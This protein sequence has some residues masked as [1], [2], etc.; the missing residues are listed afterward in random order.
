[1]IK[2][3]IPMLS[4]HLGRSVPDAVNEYPTQ[5]RRCGRKVACL[6][7]KRSAP[8]FGQGGAFPLSLSFP[9]SVSGGFGGAGLEGFRCL[10][11]SSKRGRGPSPRHPAR[12]I[13][14]RWVRAASSERAVGAPT[15]PAGLG[16]PHPRTHLWPPSLPVPLAG[17]TQRGDGHQVRRRRPGPVHG[18]AS[19]SDCPCPPPPSSPLPPPP[20]SPPFVPCAAA[21]SANLPCV[22]ASSGRR[23][24]GTGRRRRAG[25]R[26]RAQEPGTLS[27][28]ADGDAQAQGF[29]RIPGV[30]CGFQPRP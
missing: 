26:G 21:T 13:C 29:R 20:T 3:Q 8:E 23:W 14:G 1:M 30:G 5:T 11:V 7:G 12:H 4:S 9:E 25:A 15:P 17:G 24:E 27:P 19:V 18:R 28:Q 22:I 6:V 10:G 2:P 16:H